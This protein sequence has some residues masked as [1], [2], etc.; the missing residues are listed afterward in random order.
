MVG[1][2]DRGVQLSFPVPIPQFCVKPDEGANGCAKY[3]AGLREI[4]LSAANALACAA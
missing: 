3:S 1:G 4:P 2:S